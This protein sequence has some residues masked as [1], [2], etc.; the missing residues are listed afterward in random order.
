MKMIIFSFAI[1]FI[2]RE[3]LYAQAHREILVHFNSDVER[4]SKN[5]HTKKEVK[6]KSI[7]I[8]RLLN[9]FNLD[10]ASLSTAFESFNEADTIQTTKDG[11]KI[12]HVNLSKVFS[13]KIPEGINIEDVLDSLKRL[14]EV[15]MAS[16]N[17]YAS[18]DLYSSRIVTNVLDD[19]L[20]Q[21]QWGLKNIGQNIGGTLGEPGYDIKA[22][23]AWNIFSGSNTLIGNLEGNGPYIHSEFA[24]RIV[25]G[26]NTS[27]TGHA[28]HVVGIY[29]AGIGQSGIVG[30]N[31][32]A[33]IYARGVGS[34]D[35]TN[36]PTIISGI[37]DVVSKSPVVINN[38]WA[39]SYDV[40]GDQEGR[41][42]PFVRQAFANAYKHD[43]VVVASAGNKDYDSP[44]ANIYQYPAGFAGAIAVGSITNRGLKPWFS[45]YHDYVDIVAPGSDILSTYPPGLNASC[46]GSP[47]NGYICESGTSQAAPHVTGIVSL[48]RGYNPGLNNDDVENI[49][50]LSANKIKPLIY[51]Y[52]SKG[53]NKEVGHG[54]VDAEK[55]LQLSNPA[56]IQHLYTVGGYDA[57]LTRIAAIRFYGAE[58]VT[59][60]I[61]YG[62]YVH[63][64][65]ATVPLNASTSYVW[66]RGVGTEG[67]GGTTGWADEGP[68]NFGLPLCEVVPGSQTASSVTLRTYVYYIT[69]PL[70]NTV[71]GWYP[72]TPQNVQFAY[73]TIGQ[74]TPLSTGMEGVSSILKT[75][76]STWTAEPFGGNGIYTYQWLLNGA[77]VGSGRS[78]TLQ[79]N[80][81]STLQVNVTSAG[82]SASSSIYITTY[83][84]GGGGGGGGCPFVF[85]QIDN[86]MIKDNNILHRSEFSKNVGSD[87]AD[88]YKLNTRPDKVGNSF[89]LQI[90]ELDD[91]HSYF[92]KFALY[93]IDHPDAMQIGVTEENETVM[94][95]PSSIVWSSDILVNSSKAIPTEGAIEVN[96]NDKMSVKF[97]GDNIVSLK[98]VSHDKN[99]RLMMVMDFATYSVIVPKDPITISTSGSSQ[100]S[101]SKGVTDFARREQGSVVFVPID[102]ASNLDEMTFDW[103]RNSTIS[104]IGLVAVKTAG[105]TK[106]LL[107]LKSAIH[108]NY[109][110]V[111]RFL[112]SEDQ[113]YAELDR[114][115]KLDL[116]FESLSD[117]PSGL[118][119]DFTFET[120]GRYDTPMTSE[121]GEKLIPKNFGLE[122]NF[123]N[124]FNPTT[125]IKY[126]LKS[127]ENVTL[128]IYNALGEEVRTLVNERQG[129]S[130]YHVVWNGKDLAGKQV[131]SGVYIYRLK[132]GDFIQSR[133]M[134]LTK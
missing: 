39:L 49:L 48:M 7:K 56:N 26:S 2:A 65:R 95:D 123:P 50:K 9:K 1:L 134:L 87:I 120:V 45:K 4:A 14:P 97:L 86:T 118:I 11:R 44:D 40:I 67:F 15:A 82:Q 89:K 13:I 64:V 3:S 66:G 133:K 27:T 108:S 84:S 105:F 22:E 28:T 79:I 16:V 103:N 58:G 42:S 109:G 93:A 72:T 90:Q 98:S 61:Y 12:K 6:I 68:N 78:V 53:W 69:E 5:D 51:P 8:K 104:R 43:I 130:T 25:A 62:V 59:D 74:A 34:K 23:A 122:Q 52:D 127:T 125:T 29:S 83:T 100:M 126:A 60:K 116:E 117:V 91:D 57:G 19:N 77:Y 32:Y 17:G 81:N 121:T 106:T 88:L 24:S 18:D 70:T 31:P 94:Y 124:P 80:Y 99:T 21:Y 36:D 128:T 55:A 111:K 96:K 47:L 107:P 54:L 129:A 33:R 38:S 41:Y 119:R 112:S 71:Y 92:D 132:A 115:D 30:V 131:S 76:S 37:N 114:S 73:T 63:E 46:V 75:S 20:F 101:K 85:T 113:K 110:S 35:I 10:S 102:E